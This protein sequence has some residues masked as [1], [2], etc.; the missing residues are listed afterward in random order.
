VPHRPHELGLEVQDGAL[1]DP[2]TWDAKVENFLL[3]FL[4]PHFGQAN[5]SFEVDERTN[6]SKS[7]SHLAHA[8]S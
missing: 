7:F 5:S 8:Y 4:D 6:N 1:P 2:F 3:T